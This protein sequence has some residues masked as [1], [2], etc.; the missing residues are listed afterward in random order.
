M[1]NILAA[2]GLGEQAGQIQVAANSSVPTSAIDDETVMIEK[3]TSGSVSPEKLTF[4]FA[5]LIAPEIW[6]NVMPVAKPSAQQQGVSGVSSMSP[7]S[8]LTGFKLPPPPG[9]GH[10][11]PAVSERRAVQEMEAQLEKIRKDLEDAK[12][13]ATS[14]T[15]RS[16]EAE[17]ARST[18]STDFRTKL[19]EAD[20][21]INNLN[22]QLAAARKEA[23]DAKSKESNVSVDL[24]EKTTKLDAANAD[25]SRLTSAVAQKQSQIEDKDK[26]IRN[27]GARISSLMNQILPADQ[28]ADEVNLLTVVYDG[29]NWGRG[30]PNMGTRARLTDYARTRQ[31]WEIN[32]Q[33]MCN[34]GDPAPG[35]R[36]YATIVYR[37]GN[38]GPVQT[39]H[40]PE[41]TKVSFQ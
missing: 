17:R 36:K 8:V 38:S 11:Y 37:R 14:A 5:S 31:V 28:T 1:L 39:I 23:D 18:A 21:N 32:N 25:L 2:Q 6:E 20:Y 16:Q 29:C 33:T 34:G 30:D 24:T 26:E 27:Q 3:P 4:N 12:Q 10:E 40:A 19:E 35:K 13:A 9:D 7:S 41:G 22:N 15:L